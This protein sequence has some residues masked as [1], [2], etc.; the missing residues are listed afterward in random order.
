MEGKYEIPEDLLYT[1]EHEWVKVDGD[2]AICGITD[3]AQKS[4]SDIVFVELPEV[5]KK[6]E[7]GEVVCTV[8]S[9]KAVSDVYAPMSGEVVEVNE[10]LES[11]PELINNSPYKDGWIFK[12]KVAGDNEKNKEGLLSPEEYRKLVEELEE[13]RR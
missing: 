8:E 10:K 3:Y 9:V 1:E 11:S 5:G 7:K 4:L 2:I 6:V 12:L 13:G